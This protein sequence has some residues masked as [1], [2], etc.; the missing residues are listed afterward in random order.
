VGMCQLGALGMALRGHGHEAIVRHYFPQTRI[1]R[2][3]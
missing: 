2:L 3:Y 1:E